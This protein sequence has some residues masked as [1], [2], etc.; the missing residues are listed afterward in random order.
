[1]FGFWPF[2]TRRPALH[3]ITSERLPSV[4]LPFEECKRLLAA[5]ETQVTDADL[6]PILVADFLR[7][8]LLL[9]SERFIELVTGLAKPGLPADA[10]NALLLLHTRGSVAREHSCRIALTRTSH[11]NGV[12]ET[13][14]RVFLDT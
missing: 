14:M 9:P 6:R 11:W 5:L 3:V 8:D 12:I 4:E 10:L 13:N 7:R 2:R 1:M